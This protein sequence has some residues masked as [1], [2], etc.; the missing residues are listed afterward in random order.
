MPSS[1]PGEKRTEQRDEE[2]V[3]SAQGL[4]PEH[5]PP[6]VPIKRNVRKPMTALSVAS[7]TA[8][9]PPGKAEALTLRRCRGW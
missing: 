2:L 9:A 1:A 6:H 4:L 5:L 7:T 8:S 3:A